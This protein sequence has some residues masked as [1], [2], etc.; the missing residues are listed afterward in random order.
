MTF[1]CKTLDP[2]PICHGGL[3]DLCCT[4]Q[5]IPDE[6]YYLVTTYDCINSLS[7]RYEQHSGKRLSSEHYWTQSQYTPFM[8][9]TPN[10]DRLQRIQKAA[11]QT[12]WNPPSLDSALVFG[13]TFEHQ[14]K[15]LPPQEKNAGQIDVLAGRGAKWNE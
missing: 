8:C 3:N 9:T 5:R 2:E 15:C 7:C 12:K 4:W 11:V 1:F 13:G 6:T 10:C 14:G